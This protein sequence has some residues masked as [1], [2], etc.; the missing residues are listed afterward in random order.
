M[1]DQQN[2]ES[3]VVASFTRAVLDRNM[4]VN[5]ASFERALL[6]LDLSGLAVLDFGSGTG[7]LLRLLRHTNADTLYAF[8]VMPEHLDPEIQEWLRNPDAK[9]RLLLNPEHCK[10]DHDAP[11]GDLTAYDYDRILEQHD[12]FAI[13]SNPPYFLYNRILSLT[14]SDKFAGALMITSRGRLHNHPDWDVVSIMDGH[15]FDPPAYNA[16]YLLQTGFQGRTVISRETQPHIQGNPQLYPHI[17]NRSPVADM[18]DHY[19]DM[20]A[21]LNNIKRGMVP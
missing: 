8:E 15:D 13:I 10:I 16:Q 20:W 18:T 2:P 11:D 12:G 9:P 14:Q 4:T 3:P 17:N 7:N 21:Q 6:H 1:A 5:T 19:P